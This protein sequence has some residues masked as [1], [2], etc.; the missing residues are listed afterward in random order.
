MWAESYN[1][2]LRDILS[3]QDEVAGTIAR[4]VRVALTPQDRARLSGARPVDP[5]SYLLYVQGRS[6]LQHWT[7]DDL[8]AARQSF[9]RAI[10]KD[11]GYA[12]AYAGLAESYLTG[13]A[14][15]NPKVGMPLAR[16]AAAQ[17]L[18]LDDIVSDAHVWDWSGS[19]K[20]FKRAIEL[21]PGDTLAHHFYS[22]L[23]LA[24]GRN[25]ESLKQSELY[26][27][28]DPL[29]PSAYDHL[30]FQYK[31]DQQDDL[32]IAAYTKAR[33]LD[34]TWESSNW[35]LG[36]AYRHKGKSQEALAEYERSMSLDGTSTEFTR[37]LRTSFEKEGWK[38]FWT[39]K[40]NTDLERARHEYVSPYRIATYYTL[41]GHKE[42][43]FRYLDKAYADHD[44]LLTSIKSDRDFDSLHTDSRYASLLRRM[45][46]PQ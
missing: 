18:A 3:L 2:E 45:R 24:T 19:E 26:V 37:A 44:D 43:A 31:A 5:E 9:R 4:E 30:G 29:S 15:L 8:L 17:A 16:T 22:H 21:N 32:A 14:N 38:G 10:E 42:N 11:P 12:L 33:Q 27:Q 7:H 13:D 20:E 35:Y 36:D 46:L 6:A 40:L 41:L 34:P 28:L 23:L 1:R 25:Q 39:K